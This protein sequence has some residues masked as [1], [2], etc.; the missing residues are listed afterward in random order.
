[1]LT[2]EDLAEATGIAPELLLA[3]MDLGA[4]RGRVRL[5]QGRPMFKPSAIDAVHRAVEVA[6]QAAAGALSHEEA[7]FRILK[8]AA[9][10]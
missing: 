10:R 6:D 3:L 4:L 5:V 2:T 1:M 7:W 8:S 9:N